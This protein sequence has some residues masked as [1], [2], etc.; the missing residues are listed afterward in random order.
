[1]LVVESPKLG[2]KD[3]DGEGAEVSFKPTSVSVSFQDVSFNT[4]TSIEDGE[5]VGDELSSASPATVGSLEGLRVGMYVSPKEGDKVSNGWNTVGIFEGFRMGDSVG[6]HADGADVDPSVDT[7]LGAAVGDSVG[8]GAV[9]AVGSSVTGA[10]MGEDVGDTETT[11]MALGEDVG[12]RFGA[13]VGLSE[14]LII[15]S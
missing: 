14:G 9:L 5:C 2:A 1:M 3:P 12:I 4:P 10:R 13:P 6:S 8:E 7:T 11:S 15:G